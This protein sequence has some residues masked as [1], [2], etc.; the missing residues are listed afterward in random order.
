M[1]IS[2]WSSDVCSSDLDDREVIDRV[3]GR[4]LRDRREL[5]LDKADA[6][7]VLGRCLAVDLGTVRRHD[8]L[9]RPR[10][11]CDEKHGD[12]Q[13]SCAHAPAQM[14]MD[15][16]EEGRAGSGRSEEHTSDLQSLMRNSY[17]VCCLKKKT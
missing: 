17:A 6:R 2:D 8:R 16:R 7:E 10:R 3:A 12:R 9:V 14:A 13:Q 11:F 1:R 4:D 15:A 5:I